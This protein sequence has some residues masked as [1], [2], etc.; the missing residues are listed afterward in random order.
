MTSIGAKGAGEEESISIASSGGE[1]CAI[2][3]ELARLLDGPI[4]EPSSG[5]KVLKFT[6]CCAKLLGPGPGAPPGRGTAKA[7]RP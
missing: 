6:L 1:S 3:I 7:F 4:G 5:G 2:D